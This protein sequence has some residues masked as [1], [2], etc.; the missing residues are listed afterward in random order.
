MR[1]ILFLVLVSLFVTNA[2][3]Q[4]KKLVVKF[5]DITAKD[6]EK[7]VYDIDTAAQAIVLYDF[8][9]VKYE[10]NSSGNFNVL[11]NYHKRTRLINKNAFDEATVYIPLYKYGS[12]DDKLEK[13][14]ATT[15]NIENG[16]VV[17]I[18][19]DKSSVFK[20]KVNKGV[21]LYKFTFP[22]LKEGSIIEFKYTINSPIYSRLREWYFQEGYPVLWSE[23]NISVPSIYDFISTRQGYNPYAIDTVSFDKEYY[24]ILFPGDNAAEKSEVQ[25]HL[26]NTYKATWAMKNVPAIKKENFTSSLS[27]HISKISFLLSAFRYPGRAVI[28]VIGTWPQVVADLMK[29]EEFGIDLDKNNRWLEDDVKKAVSTETDDLIRAKKVFAYV[30][31]NFTCV[32]N[33]SYFLSQSLKK[34]LQLRKGNV[35]DINLLL[36]AMY[37][38]IG[39]TAKPVLLSTKE[40]GKAYEGYPIISKFNY[41]IAKLIINDKIFL[42][43]ASQPKLGF[44]KLTDDCYNGFGRTIDALPLLVNLSPDSLLESKLTSVFIVNE[45]KD[46]MSGTFKSTL[47]YYESLGLRERLAKV[48]E[49]DIFNEI[50]KSYSYEIEMSNKLL[51]SVKLYDE[52]IQLMYDFKFNPEEDIVYFTPLLTEGYKE[53]PFKASTRFYPVE[54]SY[55]TNETYVLNMETP[56]GY[57]ID[58]LPKSA[59]INLNDG[60]GMFEYII[61]KTSSGI[62][63]RSRIKINKATFDPE[64]Y[65]TLRDFYGFIVKKQSEP[66]VFKKK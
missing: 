16:E 33:T 40:N 55:A 25:S 60:D 45:E 41:A 8:G 32:D 14:E 15:Y 62:Q 46:G 23:Y 26:L 47:G 66:I 7:K 44:A 52:P 34:T 5:G 3:A 31:D 42:V 9:E 18:K 6:F 13:M 61:A 28:P 12:V 24:T 38:N 58:E 39:L 37:R 56:K 57:V 1:R 36:V 20:D 50:K 19:L 27:N 48:K 22:N 11:Y 21:T 30:R 2:I 29:D 43:D 64:D 35:A 10:G 59:R 65:Q 54:M 49:E 4:N 17:A 63:L 53:N 51:D